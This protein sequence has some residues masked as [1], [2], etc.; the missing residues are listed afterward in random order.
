VSVALET[1]ETTQFIVGRGLWNRASDGLAELL[2]TQ[3]R[4]LRELAPSPYGI[5]GV[6]QDGQTGQVAIFEQR[7]RTTGGTHKLCRLGHE[8]V[9][10]QAVQQSV[11]TEHNPGRAPCKRTSK[12]ECPPS[13]RSSSTLPSVPTH[14]ILPAPRSTST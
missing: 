11:T 3:H 5:W 13:N 2:S 8:A 9:S 7:N 10:S 14:K 6:P 12:S 4:H 1:H